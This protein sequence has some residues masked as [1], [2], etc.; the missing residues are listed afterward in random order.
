M[1]AKHPPHRKPEHSEIRSARI[2]VSAAANALAAV[3]SDPA[4]RPEAQKRL[5]TAHRALDAAITRNPS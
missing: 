4:N 3:Y 2:A 5:A 1:A